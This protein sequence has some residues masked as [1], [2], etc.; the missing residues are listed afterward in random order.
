MNFRS[1]EVGKAMVE[2]TGL[3]LH[4]LAQEV[5]CGQDMRSG[6]VRVKL[7]IV[8]DGMRWE[9]AVNGASAEQLLGD[10]LLQQALRVLEELFGFRPF[11][12]CRITPPQF[13]GVKKGRP[14]N[15]RDEVWKCDE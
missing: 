8:A 5:K 7:D 11:Q 2:L 3:L 4:L 12:D 6:F 15:E 1:D 13:P 10:N 14:I 9:K